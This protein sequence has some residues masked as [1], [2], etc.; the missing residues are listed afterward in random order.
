M[1]KTLI[2][3]LAAFICTFASSCTASDDLRFVVMGDCRPPADLEDTVTPSEVYIRNIK[4]VNLLRPGFV[5]IVGDLIRGYTDDEDEIIRQWDAFDKA[6]ELYEVS[7][8]LVV[9]NH[10]VWDK[11]SEEIYK[12]RYGDLYYSFSVGDCHFIVLDSEDMT[13]VEE[14]QSK[15]MEKIVG[16]QLEWLKKDLEKNKKKSFVFMHKPLWHKDYEQSSNW[17]EDVHPLLAKYNVDTVFAGHVHIYRKSG[18]R[19]GVKYIITGGAGAEIGSNEASGDFYHYLMVTVKGDETKIA[20]IKTGSVLSEDIVNEEKFALLEAFRRKQFTEPHNINVSDAIPDSVPFDIVLQNT[21][22]TRISATVEW[23]LKATGWLVDESRKNLELV[24]GEKKTVHFT[25][26]RPKDVNAIFPPPAWVLCFELPDTVGELRFSS[27][28]FL[29]EKYTTKKAPKTP[30]IDGRTN[31]WKGTKPVVLNK[32]RHV[33]FFGKGSSWEGPKDLSARLYFTYDDEYLYFLCDVE[34]DIFKNDTKAKNKHPYE[35]DSLILSFDS[36]NNA[37]DKSNPA[38]RTRDDDDLVYCFALSGGETIACTYDR[39]NRRIDVTDPGF[40]IRIVPKPGSGGMIYEGR[41]PWKDAFKSGPEK[42]KI[43]HFTFK[44]DED[45][46][47]DGREGVIT[48]TDPYDPASWAEF[49][50]D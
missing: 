20:V 43:G 27:P 25:L 3:T 23:N 32:E 49:I 28:V 12:Q 44:V 22:D 1:R 35:G 40:A 34:D 42:G 14:G 41:I 36:G 45:D 29:T 5:I 4:E 33:D 37:W 26:T 46:T 2:L 38:F 19:D 10:D 6:N 7:Y 9:G 17:N 30:V 31:D 11:R 16:K 8:K 39:Q 50:L 24:A 47:G 18:V 13:V 15:T 21:F 48:L